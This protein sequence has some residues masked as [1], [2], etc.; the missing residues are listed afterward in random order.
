MNSA[1]ISAVVEFDR[2]K[3]DGFAFTALGAIEFARLH[4]GTVQVQIMRHYRRADDADREVEHCRIGYDLPG[5]QQC[6]GNHV[7]IRLRQHQLEREAA[8]DDAQQRHYQC[9]DVAETAV[10]QPQNQTH[11]EC[12]STHAEN[13]WQA[14]QQ[15]KRDG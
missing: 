9:F 12:R 15:L 13:Q 5:R 6:R 2:R 14:E 10:L 3:T 4:N 11:V 7:H 1:A 8:T